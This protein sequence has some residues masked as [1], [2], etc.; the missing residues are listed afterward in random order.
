MSN[1][2]FIFGHKNPDTDSIVSS[3]A[4]SNLRNKL[5]DNTESCRLGE[6]NK[7]TESA[8]KTFHFNAP[9]LINSVSEGDSVI[10]VDHNEA[11]QSADNID[12]AN[13]R[14]V[15]DHHTMNFITNTPVYYLAE[16]V[17]CTATIIYKLYKQTMLK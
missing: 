15:V 8:L 9:K 12:K 7:E 16:P 3:I 4:M 1:K 2:T 5:G 11:T 13:I 10:L 17:G 14:M 6:I